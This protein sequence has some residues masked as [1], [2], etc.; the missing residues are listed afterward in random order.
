MP[1]ESPRSDVQG[2]GVFRDVQRRNLDPLG[3]VSD[4]RGADSL[5]QG[6]REM[7]LYLEFIA[8]H[9]WIFLFTVWMVFNGILSVVHSVKGT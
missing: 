2:A 8:A 6:D 1:D 5:G 3:A 4:E 7:T 9:P